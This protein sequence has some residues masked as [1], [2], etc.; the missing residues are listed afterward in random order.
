MFLKGG[1]GRDFMADRPIETLAELVV[2]HDFL[3]IVV[4]GEG[5]EDPL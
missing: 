4:S 2:V 3:E 5:F 1:G